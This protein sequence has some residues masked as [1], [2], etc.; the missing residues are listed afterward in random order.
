MLKGFLPKLNEVV[1]DFL[2]EDPDMATGQ[3]KGDLAH[4]TVNYQ[5][6]I[7]KTCQ[8]TQKCLGTANLPKRQVTLEG[9]VHG[10]TAGESL[11]Q[12]DLMTFKVS[13]I[14]SAAIKQDS[15]C[16][17]RAHWMVLTNSV[18]HDTFIHEFRQTMDVMSHEF[19]S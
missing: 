10:V 3:H 1:F 5:A 18:T 7:E 15:C 16:L 6:L 9:G 13:V 12:G 11:R 4:Y 2:T 8:F 19:V 14:K 17:A